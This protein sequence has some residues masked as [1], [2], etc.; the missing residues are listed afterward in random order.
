MP[1]VKLAK[2]HFVTGDV[3]R[4]A[5]FYEAILGT[6][7]LG[8]EEYVELRTR[9]TPLALCTPRA[10][11]VCGAAAAAAAR[12]RSFIL[13]FEVDDVDAA[14]RRLSDVVTEC[15][16]EPTT[17]PWGSRSMLFRDPDGNLITFF[18]YSDVKHSY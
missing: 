11:A 16:L 9:G 8:S 10:I 1:L 3:S 18:S 12:R 17:L 4:L 15:V 6:S 2:V 14:R 13:E 7:A 5:R